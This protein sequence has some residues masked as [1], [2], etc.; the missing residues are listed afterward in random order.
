MLKVAAE[1]PHPGCIA[2]LV[3]S[4]EQVRVIQNRADGL[5]SIAVAGRYPTASNS[6]TVARD[7]LAATQF[8]ALPQPRRVRPG[9]RSA[10]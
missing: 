10:R 4:G 3:G 1:F 9:R 5:V 2:Y 7:Q 6:R 8:D